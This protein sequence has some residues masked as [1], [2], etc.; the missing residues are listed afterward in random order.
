MKN[1][2]FITESQCRLLEAFRDELTYYKFYVE[3]LKFLKELLASP[4]TAQPSATLKS[5]DITREKLL[6]G[7]IDRSIVT[8]NN[9]VTEMPKADSDKKESKMLV[10]YNV[11]RKD[12]EKK[13]HRL[14]LELCECVKPKIRR[15][16]DVI[17]EEGSMGGMSCGFAMQGGGTNPNAGQ[18]DAPVNGVQRR[19]FWFPKE[20][21][22][23][24]DE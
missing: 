7:L 22:G 1:R 5:H 16:E 18:Y 4:S 17:E 24:K 14:H 3:V 15:E 6:Q 20:K 12:F 2:I 21:K 11:L 9:K 23:K 19:K 8:R 13:L 10:K